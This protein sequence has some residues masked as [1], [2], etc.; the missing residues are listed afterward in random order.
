MEYLCVIYLKP[1]NNR[2][3]PRVDHYLMDTLCKNNLHTGFD[4]LCLK[5]ILLWLGVLS[6]DDYDQL[7]IQL[8]VIQI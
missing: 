7:Y 4:S 3:L 8:P 6:S 2:I 1:I 5:E